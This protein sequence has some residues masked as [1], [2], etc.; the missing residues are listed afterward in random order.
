MIASNKIGQVLVMSPAGRL[1]AHTAPDLQEE[2]L[3]HVD[4]GD[5][6]LLL[7]MSG[8]TYVSSAGLRAILVA[9]KKL[10]EK[11]GRF[12]LCGLSDNV[13]EVF[14]VSGFSSILDIH[15][16]SASAQAALGSAG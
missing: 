5:T 13:A 9:A 3:A 14:E 7:D 8:L 15:P 16:D 10:Q 4:R 2:V 12:A 1:D 11:S 6:C